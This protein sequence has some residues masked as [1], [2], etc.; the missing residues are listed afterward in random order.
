[1]LD[2]YSLERSAV[3]DQVLANAGRVTA[4]GVMKNH[5]AQTIR[6]LI[7]GFMLGLELVRRTVADTLT[8]VTVGYAHSPL[9]GSAAH[10]IGG[11]A[12]GERAQPDAGQIPVGAGAT[13]RFALFAAPADAVQALL[14]DFPDL[15]EPT[16]RPPFS[17]GRHLAGPP[18][19]LYRRVRP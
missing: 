4:I 19:R 11:P 7:G 8:E 13:P 1:M 16:L 9:N 14:R 18:G 6:N 10:A 5:T 3:G 12:P 2:S 15:L 17:P